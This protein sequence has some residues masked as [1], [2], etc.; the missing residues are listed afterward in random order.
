MNRKPPVA[1]QAAQAIAASMVFAGLGLV[2]AVVRGVF[3]LLSPDSRAAFEQVTGGDANAAAYSVILGY[4]LPALAFTIL[5]LV[6]ALRITRGSRWT[7]VLGMLLGI[8]GIVLCF[9]TVSKLLSLVATA[10]TGFQAVLALLLLVSVRYF[11][12]AP[13]PTFS[14]TPSAEAEPS[15]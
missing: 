4:G 12:S 9:T 5:Y 10:L 11:W 2:A 15:S 8:T 7:W 1:V 14:E 6:V 13:E 3:L